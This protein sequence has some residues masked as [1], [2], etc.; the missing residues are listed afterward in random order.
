[1]SAAWSGLLSWTTVIDGDSSVKVQVTLVLV[2]AAM[3]TRRLAMSL[4]TPL[5][6]EHEREVRVQPGRASWVIV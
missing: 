3:V 1:M 4:V 5:E 6:V 2:V